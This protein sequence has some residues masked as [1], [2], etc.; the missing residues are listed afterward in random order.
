MI[1]RKWRI[2]IEDL[3]T[4]RYRVF[5]TTFRAM[6]PPAVLLTDQLRNHGDPKVPRS[7]TRTQ[8]CGPVVGPRD[9]DWTA[10][11]AAIW[12]V[13]RHATG[14]SRGRYTSRLLTTATASGRH[15]FTL[16]H[17]QHSPRFQEAS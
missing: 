17:N 14:D 1:G 2:P 7:A 5:G 12:D 10:A 11:R 8:S 13:S 15:G 4:A 6:Y 3:L 16:P 9:H